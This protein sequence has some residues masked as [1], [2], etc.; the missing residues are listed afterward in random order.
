[1][2]EIDKIHQG[3]CLELM[4]LIPDK[5][6]DMILCDLPYGTTLCKWDTVIPFENLWNNYKRIIK[7]NG[8]IVLNCQQPFTSFLI[9]SGIDIF[10]YTWCWDKNYHPNYMN[11]NKMHTKA[12]EDIAVFYKRQP[13]YNPQKFQGKPYIDTRKPKN[14]IVSEVYGDIPYGIGK[15]VSDGMR[16]PNGIIK[17]SG[18]S[19]KNVHPTQKPV[20][21]FEYL[22]KTYTNENELVLDN[23]I[24]SG[25]T[26]IA[27]IN[28]NRHFIGIEKEQK[29][30]DIANKRIKEMP[31]P[32]EKFIG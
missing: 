5:S 29:Y 15:D 13:T 12:F 18:R 21:L 17:I 24:G 22:I 20:E 9:V 31:I 8:A 32:L 6:I 3:D 30:V 7:N 2:L 16:T 25:T 1:M 11:A 28:T 10:R 19:N 14:R 26:A 27:C 23:C 4:P